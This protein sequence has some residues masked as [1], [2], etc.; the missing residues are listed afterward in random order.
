MKDYYL[1]MG[2][3]ENA[4]SGEIKSAYRKLAL[5]YHPDTCQGNKKKECEEKFK[6][7][8]AAY[9]VL[10]DEKRKKEYDDYRKG[11]YAFKS[12]PEAGD[13]ASQSGFDFE[14]LI[15]HFHNSGTRSNRQQEKTN[16]YFSFDDLSDI[17]QGINLGHQSQRSGNH[18][19]YQFNDPDRQQKQDTD[20]IAEI[21]IP[22]NIA[23]RGG[24][25]KIKLSDSRTINLKIAANTKNG[26]KLRLKGMGKMCHTCDHKGDL[27]VSVRYS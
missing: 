25:V 17:F 1:I 8:S 18:N 23:Q 14:D 22:Q 5:K 12:G 3:S 4:A 20:I 15:R 24:E 11:Q 21:N 26:Q 19:V 7:I 2:V 27:I 10:G 16:R 13:F 6:E 9:Y